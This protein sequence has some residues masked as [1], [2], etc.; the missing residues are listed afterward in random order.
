MIYNTNISK[1][2]QAKKPHQLFK[3]P[4][5][6]ITKDS[7]PKSTKEEYETFLKKIEEKEKKSKAK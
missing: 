4:Q 2:N 7:G 1:S 5:D 6:N 3:L